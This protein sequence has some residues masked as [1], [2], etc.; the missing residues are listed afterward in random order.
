VKEQE[1]D[2]LFLH[3]ITKARVGQFMEAGV[4]FHLLEDYHPQASLGRAYCYAREHEYAQCMQVLSRLKDLEG[5]SYSI[6][7]RLLRRCEKE[8]QKE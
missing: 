6:Y 2:F 8:L 3:A 4:I 1:R 7:Q 5:R